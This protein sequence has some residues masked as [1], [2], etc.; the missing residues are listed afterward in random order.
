[1]LRALVCLAFLA[2][3]CA[4]AAPLRART[5]EPV[6]EELLGGCSLRCAFR[7][8]VEV[9]PQPGAAAKAVKVF[10]DE[11]AQTAWI[12]DATTRGLG[13]QIRL[14][15][16]KK[17]P[18]EMEAQV[19]LYGLDLINGH[20]REDQWPRFA[21]LKR[22]RLLYN[23][24]PLGEVTF[25]DSRRWQRVTLPDLMIRSG[26]VLTL[27]ILELHAA[28]PAPLAITEIVLQGAH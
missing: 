3:P 24:R 4:D 13:A 25:A 12:G 19:P 10:N 16:P 15:F 9:S 14:A 28:G 18:R 1:M 7:W 22:A 17:I 20:W 26:D 23:A 11:S 27:E 6:L 5:E 8:T 2:T 21:R